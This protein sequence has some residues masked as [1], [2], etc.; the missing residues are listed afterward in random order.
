MIGIQIDGLDELNKVLR[1]GMKEYPNAVYRGCVDTG[2]RIQREAKLIAKQRTKTGNLASSI[3]THADKEE[4]T[5]MVTAGGSAGTGEGQEKDVCY[6]IYQEFGTRYMTGMFF[7]TRGAEIGFRAMP[8]YVAKRIDA[9][10][11]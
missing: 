1:E 4:K 6:A 5:V 9:E 10:V 2:F 7:M 8:D 3:A 11:K